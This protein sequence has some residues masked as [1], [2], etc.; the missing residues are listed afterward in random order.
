[1]SQRG[2]GG[3]PHERLAG[4]GAGQR[5]G[6][7][8]AARQPARQCLHADLS[9]RAGEETRQGLEARGRGVRPQG[10]REARHGL[11]PVGH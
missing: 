2:L 7:D 4:R 1:M 10:H 5:H 6:A 8:Q 3:F 9:G 11:V